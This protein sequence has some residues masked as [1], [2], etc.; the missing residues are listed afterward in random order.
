MYRSR[1]VGK[2]FRTSEEL[3]GLFAATPPLEALRILVGEAATTGQP[4]Q[5]MSIMYVSRA[6]FE[7]PVQRDV[8]IE[9][10]E[11][12]LSEGENSEDWVG[13]LHMSLYGTRGAAANWK[14]LVAKTMQSLGVAQGQYAP[15]TF[16][17]V[18][19]SLRTLVHGD[20]F[21]TVGPAEE[22]KWLHTELSKKFEVQ[23]A[24][25]GRGEECVPEARILNRIVRVTDQGWELEADQRHACILVR[26][27]GLEEAKS[28][29]TPGEAGKT[30]EEAENT[31]EL[32]ATQ[33]R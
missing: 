11:E 8:C 24:L 14:D 28:V 3:D 18:S 19:R 9:L 2:D 32:N 30:W 20:D 4:E 5:I 26:A 10:P 12:A 31:V 6:F 23:T 27:L 13:K 29:S 16:H 15:C 7:A 21:V 33:A 17:C 25:V 1:L 22:A